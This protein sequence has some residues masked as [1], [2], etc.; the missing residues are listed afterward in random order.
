MS[1]RAEKTGLTRQALYTSLSSD[2]H[3]VFASILK[4][5]RAFGLRFHP[6]RQSAP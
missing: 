5:L 2:G 3:P 1:Q 4:I 6:E